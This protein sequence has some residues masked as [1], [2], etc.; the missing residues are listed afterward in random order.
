MTLAKHAQTINLTHQMKIVSLDTLVQEVVTRQNK[1]LAQ[2]ATIVMEQHNF[3]LHVLLEH[4][5]DMSSSKVLKLVSHVFQVS[6]A[7]ETAWALHLI[8]SSFV[9][10]D[11][12]ARQVRQTRKA[13]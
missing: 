4:S 13:K 5:I 11:T 1:I 2:Q 9:A 7:Q 10:K 6:I 12:T 3:L 8:M